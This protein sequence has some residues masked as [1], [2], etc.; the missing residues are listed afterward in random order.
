[1]NVA[2]LKQLLGVA[3]VIGERLAPMTNTKVDDKAVELA[4]KIETNDVI[5][6]FVAALFAGQ[7]LN[8]HFESMAPA[9]LELAHEVQANRYALNALIAAT[10]IVTTDGPAAE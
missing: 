6:A 8:D 4:K 3:I 9:D 5:L 10:N 7:Q 1:V 2:R